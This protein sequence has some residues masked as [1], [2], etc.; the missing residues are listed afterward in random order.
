MT[1]EKEKNYVE[2]LKE[3]IRIEKKSKQEAIFSE[4][5]LR[6]LERRIEIFQAGESKAIKQV[7]E[8]IEF[9]ENNSDFHCPEQLKSKIEELAK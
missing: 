1:T 2:A 9:F 5:Y 4:K 3:L 6:Q 8:Q 7:M